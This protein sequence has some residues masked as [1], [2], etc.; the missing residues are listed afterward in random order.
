[1]S[2]TCRSSDAFSA[3][4]HTDLVESALRRAVLFRDPPLGL[5]GVVFH[6]DRGCQY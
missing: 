1:M 3:S 6:A 4:L 5:D 2:S